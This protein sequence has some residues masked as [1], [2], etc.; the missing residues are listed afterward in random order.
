MKL[1]IG[2]VSEFAIESGISEAFLRLG[3]RALGYFVLHVGGRE[4]GVRAPDATLLGCSFDEVG[5]RIAA[6]GSHQAPFSAVDAS[7]IAQS[8]RAARYDPNSD[9]K[10][11]LGMRGAQLDELVTSR[12]LLWAPDGDQAFDDGSFVI[13]MDL[14]ESARLIAFKSTQG[15]T[16]DDGSLRDVTIEAKAFDALLARWYS[17]FES[18]WSTL[19]A[20]SRSVPG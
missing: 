1:L 10:W 13:Q 11:M 2:E 7:E 4:Y 6:K 12:N 9:D 18:Q 14:G 5:R 8:I 15:Y 19:I 3:A 17:E 16:V 20:A